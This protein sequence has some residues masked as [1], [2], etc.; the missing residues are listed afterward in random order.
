M[1]LYDKL[2]YGTV[3]RS[4]DFWVNFVVYIYIYVKL[5]DVID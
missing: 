2:G 3:Q 5:L 4:G 1:I